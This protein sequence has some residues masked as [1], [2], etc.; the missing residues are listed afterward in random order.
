METVNLQVPFLTARIDF[1]VATQIDR[2]FAATL[3]ET[4]E[5]FGRDTFFI[6]RKDDTVRALPI[7]R[8]IVRTGEAR[9][10]VEVVDGVGARLVVDV[11]WTTCELGIVEVDEVVEL[12]VGIV[13]VVEVVVEVVV[14]GPTKAESLNETFC[15][16]LELAA[17]VSVF[18]SPKTPL[19]L[20]PQQRTALSCNSEQTKSPPTVIA[21]ATAAPR[22]TS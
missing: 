14:V 5:P 17:T 10:V 18:P 22:L 1:D 16:G 13:E 15:D 9:T 8:F 3:N 12:L 11:L 6:E 7:F 2:D 20:P 4:L 19:E 21:L